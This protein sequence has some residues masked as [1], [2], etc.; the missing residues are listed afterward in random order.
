MPGR[1]STADPGRRLLRGV[2]LIGLVGGCALGYLCLLVRISSVDA[3]CHRLETKCEELRTVI[4][5]D[6]TELSSLS[7]TATNLDRAQ[8]NGLCP[9]DGEDRLFVSRELCRPNAPERGTGDEAAGEVGAALPAG[10]GA[11]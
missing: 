1:S 5:T 7:D 4:A 3:A 6:M 11:Y 9:P 2:T 8:S 10:L